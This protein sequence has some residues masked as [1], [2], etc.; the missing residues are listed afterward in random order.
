MIYLSIDGMNIREWHVKEKQEYRITV[1]WTKSFKMTN[2]KHKLLN[3]VIISLGKKDVKL[4]NM[5]KYLNHVI[6]KN[7][8]NA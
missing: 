8:P 2:G 6:K 5:R 4:E 3:R 1:L 7:F